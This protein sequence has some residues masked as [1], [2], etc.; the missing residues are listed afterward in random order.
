MRDRA[1]RSLLAVLFATL[2]ASHVAYLSL[3]TFDYGWNMLVNIAVSAVAGLL[4]IG[5]AVVQREPHAWRAVVTVAALSAAMSL[6]LL[7]FPPLWWTLDAH[8]LWHAATVPTMLMWYRFLTADSL[9]RRNK[10]D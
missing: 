6:E 9:S 5:W 7:D 10:L 2:Y 3:V 1:W 4:W 8:A